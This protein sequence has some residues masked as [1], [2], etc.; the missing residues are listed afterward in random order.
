MSAM[1]GGDHSEPLEMPEE[2]GPLW[3]L[4]CANMGVN[5][6][7]S[8]GNALPAGSRVGPGKTAHAQC[9]VK[10]TNVRESPRLDCNN[11]ALSLNGCHDGG[12][13]VAQF[14][15]AALLRRLGDHPHD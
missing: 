9:A 10:T 14:A 3:S 2:G 4:S 13:R 6:W 12:G 5:D 1:T 7:K 8:Q 11:A 15:G